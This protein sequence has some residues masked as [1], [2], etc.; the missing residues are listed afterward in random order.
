MIIFFVLIFLI[1]SKPVRA[2]QTT[3]QVEIPAQVI[4]VA[5]GE[6]IE[7]IYSNLGKPPTA[8]EI[9]WKNKVQV[10][11]AGTELE[12]KFLA[13]SETIDWQKAGIIYKNQT[14]WEKITSL[15]L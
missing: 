6:T 8:E 3:L 5:T 15:I 4:V 12:R 14:I 9:I 11:T 13:L 10:I 7:S 2:A 1:S